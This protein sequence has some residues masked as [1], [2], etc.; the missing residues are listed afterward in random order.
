MLVRQATSHADAVPGAEV[1]VADAQGFLTSADL[2][3]K[4]LPTS[5]VNLAIDGIDGPTLAKRLRLDPAAVFTRMVDNTVA[6]DVRTITEQEI[7]PI[8]Q[9]VERVM[10]DHATPTEPVTAASAW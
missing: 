6:L 7:V 5:L 8:A 3:T 4:D 9:A 2:P 1:Q 10:K